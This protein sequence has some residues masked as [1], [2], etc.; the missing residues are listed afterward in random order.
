MQ[1]LVIT[2]YNGSLYDVA[3]FDFS[4]T[5]E[6]TLLDLDTGFDR[7]VYVDTDTDDIDVKSYI[8][9]LKDDTINRERSTQCQ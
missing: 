8:N 7:T 3:G 9:S 6:V 2:V 5:V 4:D 1:R